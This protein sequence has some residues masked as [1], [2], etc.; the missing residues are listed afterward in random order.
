MK[1]MKKLI[2]IIALTFS[3]LIFKA[4]AKYYLSMA[5]AQPWGTPT[6]INAMNTAFGA[7]TWTQA[8][9]ATVN[10]NALLQ[11]SVCLIFMEGGS[12]DANA[13][14][15]FLITNLPAIQA[16]VFNGGRLLMNSAP[17]QGGNINYGFGGVIRNYNPGPWPP[18]CTFA[19]GQAGHPIFAGPFLPC[20]T[21]YTGNWWCHGYVT[22]PA[23]PLIVSA[24]VPGCSLAELNWGTGKAMFG[25][26]TTP[27]WH[28]PAVNAANLLANILTYLYVCCTQPTITAVANPTSVCAG[29]PVTVTAS[30]AGIGGTYTWTPPAPGTTVVGAVTV[31]TPAVTGIYTVAGTNTAGCV[32]TRTLQIVVNPNPTIT[33]VA[34]PTAVCVGQTSSTIT[35]G[36]GVSYTTQP[37]NFI[38]GVVVVSPAVPTV[39]TITGVNANG[40]SNTTTIQIGI[41]PTTTATANSPSACV[42][43]PINLSAGGGTGFSWTGPN[44]FTSNLQNPVIPVAALNMAGQYNVVVTSAVGCTNSAVSTVSVVALPNPVI[45]SNAPLCF[46]GTL[47]LTGNGGGSYAWSGPNGFVSA[48]QTPSIPNVNLFANGVYSLVTVVNTC[49]AM[50]TASIL[51]NPLPSPLIQS[52]SPV[53]LFQQITFTLSGGI[54]YTLAGPGGYISN[55][56]MATIPIANNVTSGVYTL[57]TNDNNSCVNS[58][59][60]SVFINPLPIISAVGST[61]CA[62]KTI[63]LSVSGGTAYTWSGPAGFSSN[64][65]N[66]LIPNGDLSMAG[67]YTVT[68][69]NANGCV[70]T[71]VTNV[72]VKTLPTPTASCNTPI[73]TGA[74]IKLTG[75]DPL[76]VNYL[77]NGPNGFFTLEQNPTINLAQTSMSGLYTLTATDP[78]GCSGQVLVTMLI[79]P[80]P[81][82][83]ISANKSKGCVPVCATFTCQGTNLLQNIEWQLNDQS[84]I[85]SG[86]SINNCFKFPGNY[87]I[88]ASFTDQNG[89]SSKSQSFEV[90]A[91]PIPVADFNF[92]PSKP[93]VNDD[94]EFTDAS[95]NA[96][97]KEYTWHFTDQLHDI[98]LA[99]NPHAFYENA[100]SYPVALIV[101]SDK[102]CSDTIVK[103]VVVG[104]DFSIYVPNAF[105]PNGDGVNEFF[106]PKGFGIVKYEMSVF[107]RWGEKLFTTT[108]FALG[109]DGSNQKKSK[110]IVETGVYV[111]KI[112]V[113]NVFG[114]SKE[115]SGTV[116]LIK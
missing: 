110:E 52:N 25:S 116:S 50:A 13:M 78:N 64:A 54:S 2:L 19:P 77:W 75:S 5:V 43:A 76:A 82:A 58:S 10:V 87:S 61:V 68:A 7:G 91:Y 67:E 22:G 4:Q 30:G 97:V 95:H 9:Y 45:A 65:T 88:R 92:A 27:N 86:A 39:Y 81:T 113:T 34:N 106:Q 102:G 70:S 60:A 28:Q 62:N 107:N 21:N 49:S 24:G 93:V 94:I 46:G 104:E 32:G 99:P 59:T 55:N 111:W 37:I 31:F 38:G 48:V 56:P 41:N 66:P 96:L 90:N 84:S 44:G 20:G 3:A 105:T 74:D 18:N 40:C 100:G 23:T 114:K 1:N 35:L 12:L 6:N 83:L 51:I 98:S 108:D 57:T 29:Q 71:S 73:C 33:A 53:C 80:I 115:M 85:G 26:M 72:S 79:N 101:R 109:W 103:N 36:G 42:G 69:T 112:Q 47:N 16:W 63:S 89:C 14:N 11:P 15:N 17:N 8:Q